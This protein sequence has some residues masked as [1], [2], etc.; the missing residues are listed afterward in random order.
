ML[1]PRKGPTAVYNPNRSCIQFGDVEI[2]D[3]DEFLGLQLR[4]I[5]TNSLASF[6][7]KEEEWERLCKYA[8]REEFWDWREEAITEY[9]AKTGRLYLPNKYY[10]R[11]LAEIYA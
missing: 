1:R 5:D 2:F 3:L 10:Q 6:D 8:H 11:L 9:F 4:W 7:Q